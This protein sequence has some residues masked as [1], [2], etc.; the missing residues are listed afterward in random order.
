MNEQ[1]K[2]FYINSLTNKNFTNENFHRCILTNLDMNNSTFN[3]CDFRSAEMKCA[4][5]DFAKF[6]YAKLIMVEGTWISCENAI[7]QNTLILH[8][9]FTFGNFKNSDFANA[10]LNN[11]IFNSADLRGAIMECESI[12]N[13]DFTNAIYDETTVWKRGFN[14]VEYGAILCQ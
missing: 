7:L 9:D 12:E 14:P 2:K 4:V 13:C 11:S 8:S 10:K 6:K 5:V 3:Y 1:P